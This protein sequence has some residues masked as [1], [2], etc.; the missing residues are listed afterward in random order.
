MPDG[1]LHVT[2]TVEGAGVPVLVTDPRIGT[3]RRGVVGRDAQERT[4]STA[5]PARGDDSQ[6]TV[7]GTDRGTTGRIS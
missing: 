6:E 3:T 5:V 1:D 4:G 7:G 2:V